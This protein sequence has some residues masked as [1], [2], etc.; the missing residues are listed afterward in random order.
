MKK[1]KMTDLLRLVL[2][3]VGLGVLF[4]S[5]KQEPR[6]ES[7]PVKFQTRVYW[8]Y[9]VFHDIDPN[10]RSYITLDADSLHQGDEKNH[11]QICCSYRRLSSTQL[12]LRFQ[13]EPKS[14]DMI[15][16]TTTEPVLRE[17]I[18]HFAEFPDGT[19]YI[20]VEGRV[21]TLTEVWY[22]VK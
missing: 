13:T 18:W 14:F 5:C 11:H 10:S 1:P 22:R 2:I 21:S 19:A 15:N 8:R 9:G 17:V 3:I 16:Q 6:Q 4:L 20:G 7:Q 12:E